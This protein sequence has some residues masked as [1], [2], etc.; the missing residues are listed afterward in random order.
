[1]TALTRLDVYQALLNAQKNTNLAALSP[2]DRRIVDRMILDRTRNGLGL[3]PDKR[4][5]LLAIKK[6]IMEKA[7]DFSRNCNEESGSLLFT[8]EV[9][10]SLCRTLTDVDS[11]RICRSLKE[12][13]PT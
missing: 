9:S 1:M 11:L 3:S 4:E 8:A 7:V 13:L 12:S 6:Q 2:E 5:A 10:F